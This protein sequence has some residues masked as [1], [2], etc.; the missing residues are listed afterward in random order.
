MNSLF[1]TISDFPLFPKK[2]KDK[3]GQKNLGKKGNKALREKR[4]LE[5]GQKLT[6][7][8]SPNENRK[9]KILQPAQLL[10]LIKKHNRCKLPRKRKGLHYLV[11]LSVNF[12]KWKK[13][14]KSFFLHFCCQK[15]D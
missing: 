12:L 3:K 6:L 7:L 10:N 5:N 11:G 8:S 15:A 13:E 9:R 14:K 2:H 1:Y 4:N